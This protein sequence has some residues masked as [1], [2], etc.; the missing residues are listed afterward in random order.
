MHRHHGKNNKIQKPIYIQSE[1]IQ[2]ISDDNPPYPLSSS[3]CSST[4]FFNMIMN[5]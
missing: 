4:F 1:E 5:D 2:M 3:S